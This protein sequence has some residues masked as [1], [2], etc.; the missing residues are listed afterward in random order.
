MSFPRLD[1]GV[2]GN[3]VK[4]ESAG[5]D[6]DGFAI[7]GT[8]C[9][10]PGEPDACRLTCKEEPKACPTN[11]KCGTDGLCRA[12]S[13]RFMIASATFEE[14]SERILVGDFDGDRAKDVMVVGANEQRVHYF[15]P[16]G[17]PASTQKILGVNTRPVI[18]K[19]T[20][21][22]EVM[23][24]DEAPDPTDDFAFLVGGGIG[25][26]R[27]NPARSFAPAQYPV[28]VIQANMAASVFVIDAVQKIDGVEYPGD[29]IM[30]IFQK[31]NAPTFAFT[32]PSAVDIAPHD[33]PIPGPLLG[34]VAVA[35]LYGGPA[36]GLMEP[37]CEEA[38]FAF[39]ANTGSD[40]ITIVSPCYA[41]MGSLKAKASISLGA[42]KLLGAP[43]LADMDA[44]SRI[45][46]VAGGYVLDANL[47]KCHVVAIAYNAGNGAFLPP[48][49][50]NEYRKDDG[51]CEFDEEEPLALL[52]A[53]DLD[54]DG[55]GDYIDGRGVHRGNVG[56]PFAH[57]A[58]PSARW[59]SAL[60]EDL[61]ADGILDGIAGSEIAHEITFLQGTGNPDAPWSPVVI[62]TQL[63]T[64]GFV[65][66]YF[67]NDAVRDVAVIERSGFN[68]MAPLYTTGDALSVLYGRALTSPEPP[69]QMG[70]LDTIHG[71]ISGGSVRTSALA[72]GMSD[73]LVTAG[74]T[75]PRKVGVTS[76]GTG[77]QDVLFFSGSAD[78]TLQSPFRLSTE[79]PHSKDD[80]KQEERPNVPLQMALGQFNDDGRMDIAALSMQQRSVGAALVV[81]YFAWLI[82]GGPDAGLAPV[83]N[84]RLL[85]EGSF[86]STPS[87]PLVNKV[88][89][90]EDLN[91]FDTT[92]GAIDLDGEAPDE[93][94]GFSPTKMGV[95]I[96]ILS[97]ENRPVMYKDMMGMEAERVVKRFEL[98][99]ALPPDRF[100]DASQVTFA[101]VDGDGKKDILGVFTLTEGSG[102]PPVQR[103]MVFIN[104]SP[105][106][107]GMNAALF[108]E[109][110][111][112]PV[113]AGA[114]QN[115]VGMPVRTFALLNADTDTAIEI[116][117]ITDANT[118]IYDLADGVYKFEPNN[119]PATL[120]K[121]RKYVVAPGGDVAAAGDVNN[122]GIDDLI[123]GSSI[124]NV[125]SV[126]RGGAT[127]PR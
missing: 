108:K 51:A 101:D 43:R 39:S 48:V 40:S 109:I 8:P 116:A 24:S 55:L 52:A 74:K 6:C 15:D 57:V 127:N 37:V 75:P 28:A 20:P 34:D 4:E 91:L 30:G 18:G 110:P 111:D 47:A 31:A 59:S 26:M 93:I 81:D 84:N 68:P 14:D 113:P 11:Y 22:H 99:A 104:N 119:D 98:H 63:P 13:G 25:V 46:I 77:G 85:S 67:D 73:I 53:G 124:A 126:Y 114:G 100:K 65:S 19:L 103:L 9:A 1:P 35:D 94:V 88:A 44:D 61:N 66:G 32:F 121:D 97:A 17:A 29:E 21:P 105:G 80:P 12:P 87:E 89:D 125:V 82:P 62:P 42:V 76:S 78:R 112:P 118:F 50:I 79:G 86:L 83:M 58:S 45:D 60:I 5:E 36:D 69:V 123:I 16:N 95:R 7:E 102:A 41:L 70:R 56:E 117:V 107:N 122:D 115:E 49:L 23:G 92:I 90:V 27:G 106:L 3:G 96:S 64:T 120:E 33:E 38:V 54:G 72:D 71:I 10:A 2:C